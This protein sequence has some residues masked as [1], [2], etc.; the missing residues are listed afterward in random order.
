MKMAKKLTEREEMNQ[1][2]LI[3]L[4]T[5]PQKAQ[6]IP[7]LTPLE[8]HL[9]KMILKPLHLLITTMILLL[10][11]LNY[12]PNLGLVETVSS[13]IELSKTSISPVILFKLDTP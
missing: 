10:L 6:H 3:H 1:T 4:L 13:P 5:A 7:H 12:R 9:L 2:K 11:R 8:I